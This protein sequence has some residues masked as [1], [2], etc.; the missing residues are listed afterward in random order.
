M[1]IQATVWAQRNILGAEFVVLGNWVLSV[2]VHVRQN[3][4]D[5]D[6]TWLYTQ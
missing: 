4:K 5:I 6:K 1:E 2:Y 3:G